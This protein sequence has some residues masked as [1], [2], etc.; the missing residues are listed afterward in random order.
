MAAMAAALAAGWLTPRLALAALVAWI[1]AALLLAAVPAAALAPR[2]GPVLIG[3]IGAGAAELITPGSRPAGDPWPLVAMMLGSG[4]LWIAGAA[5][6]VG[7]PAS[8]RRRIGAFCLLATPWFAAVSLGAGD[9]AGWVG[10]VVLLAGLLWFSCSRAAL[11]I[12]VVAALLSVTAAQAVGPRTRWFDLAGQPASK[13]PFQ[14]LSTEPTYGPL[15][16]RRTGA[17]MLDI[18]APEPALWRMQTLDAFDGARW[19]VSFTPLPELP[20]PAARTE[21]VT[22]H[23]LG[24]RND[25]VVAPGRIQQVDARGKTT[26]VAGEAWRVP[27][28]LRAGSTY[29]VSSDF[30]QPAAAQLAR[31]RAPIDRRA[32]AYT[33]LGATPGSLSELDQLGRVLLG[34]LGVKTSAPPVV[35]PDRGV[36]ALARR[37][38][39]GAETEWEVVARVERF[40][41]DGRR[42]RYTTR[43]PPAGPHPLDDFLL[44][45]RAGHCQ[46]FAGAAALLL[47][48]AGVPARVVAGFATGRRTAPGQY[49][50]RDLDAHD[51]I[52][53]YFEGYGW[54]PFNPTPRD[55]GATIAGGIDPLM[56]QA[57]A[58]PRGRRLATSA[59]LSALAALAAV[60]VLRRRRAGRGRDRL[61]ELL[62]RIARRTGAGLGP[63]STLSELGAVLARVGPRTA[64][65][66][67]EAERSRFA[68]D[69]PPPAQHPR[70][71]LARTLAG[72]LGA[73]RAILVYVPA[74]NRRPVPSVPP[75][76]EEQDDEQRQQ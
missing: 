25:L 24:L 50:V 64:A 15:E 46:Q 31:D 13:P 30:V 49:T 47:R 36:V 39:A 12:G 21:N 7:A 59:G 58:A 54:V 4:A 6:A 33:R 9:H 41:L 45:T 42:F 57:E 22:V 18:A 40:L 44:R 76:V 26:A 11:G 14:T 38:S 73:L 8:T 2:A 32:R 1:P 61:P 27:S 56:R 71:Q 62:E 35:T 43:V 51:W 72:D 67:A 19:G 23:V 75:T 48:L 63:S 68:A 10:A 16:D 69:A 28:G 17:A 55:A 53:V 66:A 74:V 60:V 29:R 52:E 34:S 3:Q 5:L 70:L 37:L 20:Q 65:L